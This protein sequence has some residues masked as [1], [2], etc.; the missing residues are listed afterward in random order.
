MFFFLLFFF[1]KGCSLPV[2]SF[3]PAAFSSLPRP[4]F[5]VLPCSLFSVRYP[6]TVT[7]SLAVWLVLVHWCW[8][9]CWKLFTLHAACALA[10]HKPAHP[11]MIIDSAKTNMQHSP[12]YEPRHKHKGNCDAAV[13]VHYTYP[14][15]NHQ[16]ERPSTVS[17]VD[18]AAG[19]FVFHVALHYR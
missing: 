8:C 1:L 18:L 15:P 14:H 3:S 10:A 16:N 2:F 12:W 17:P 7:L 13:N 6:L 4:I 5:H 9:W 11:A 19:L